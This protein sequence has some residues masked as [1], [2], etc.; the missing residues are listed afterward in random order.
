M[1]LF[2]IDGNALNSVYVVS[3][4]NLKEAYDVEGDLI[5]PDGVRL[6]VMTY[7]V[8]WFT[9]INSQTVMQNIIINGNDPDIIGL[10]EVSQNGV[11]PSVGTNV[12]SNYPYKRL[13]NHKN[14]NA[15]AS[16]IP[17]E[18]VV[19]ADFVNQDPNEMTQYNE[20]RAY[21]ITDIS[22]SGKTI[23]WINTHLCVLSSDVRHQQFGELL[24]MADAFI[25][26]GYPVVMT[27]DFNSNSALSTSGADYQEMYKLCVDK[28]YHLANC[29]EESGFTKTHSSLTTAS[30][31]EDLQKAL[32][33]IIV[34][35]DVMIESV[36]FDTTKF[37]YLNGK[38]IDHI[39]VIA[40]L[41]I[42]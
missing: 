13:S 2:S 38:A 26:S 40:E 11:M 18:N 29:T 4:L 24:D 30:S 15:F 1:A 23:K 10:Q 28:G 36:K 39:A 32:D 3:G 25:A 17:L 14:Y 35:P 16:K 41:L 27:G 21:M 8:Q 42:H 6:K 22:V 20:T 34:S 19:I 9:G 12:L 33:N 37:S 31:L 5:F 7:N